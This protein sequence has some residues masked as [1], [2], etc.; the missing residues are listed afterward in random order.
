MTVEYPGR[1]ASIILGT[2]AFTG[3]FLRLVTLGFFE[4][5]GMAFMVLQFGGESM[6]GLFQTDPVPKVESV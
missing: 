5:S 1:V 4:R 2:N 3:F 6:S